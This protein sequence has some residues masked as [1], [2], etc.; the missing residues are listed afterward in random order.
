MLTRTLVGIAF[1]V[2]YLLFLLAVPP[3]FLALALACVVARASFE[4]LRATK[5]A[6][7]RHM[8][9]ITA[10]TAA[11]IPLGYVFDCGSL[12][13]WGCMLALMVGLFFTAVRYYDC[14]DDTVNYEQV[15]TCMFGGLLI[16]VCLSS[17]VQ[18]RM[19]EN[20]HFLVLLP[21]ICASITDVGAYFV[22]MFL[23][24]HR[25]VTRVSP[26]KSLEGYVGGIVVGCL[27][28][29]L[30]ALVLRQWA[31]IDA[32]MPLLALYGLVGCAVTELGDLA[33]SLIKRQHG[34]KDYG[35]LMPGHGGMMDRF[36]STV[37]AAPTI[38][39]LVE[40]FPAF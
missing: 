30:Y 23:G 25:G 26:N 2:V 32:S 14:G 6:T 4:L 27:V 10:C 31:G 9:V 22:G 35:H 18:L 15:F 39:L 40:L 36:D 12:V 34:V 8:Y 5:A 3:Q 13:I 21:V 17:L 20:G 33:F 38:L 16:P 28:M 19:M 11:A 24:K 7:H 29:M 37:F 1:A